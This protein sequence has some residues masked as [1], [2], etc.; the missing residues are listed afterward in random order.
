MLVNI[1]NI[2]TDDELSSQNGDTTDLIDSSTQD[3]GV[4]RFSENRFPK[5]DFMLVDKN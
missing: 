4:Y 3:Y 5:F 2:C 1:L